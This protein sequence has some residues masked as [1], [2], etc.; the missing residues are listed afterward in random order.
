VGTSLER[1]PTAAAFCSWLRL[2]PEPGISGGRV[3]SC[4]TRPTKNRLDLAL[5][6]SAL[7]PTPKSHS[8]RYKV[9]SALHLALLT[10]AYAKLERSGPEFQQMAVRIFEVDVQLAVGRV[11]SGPPEFHIVS[12]ECV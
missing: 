3:L 2:C 11:V 7:G 6:V 10:G 8:P 4:K 12:L 5:I 9:N 1:F